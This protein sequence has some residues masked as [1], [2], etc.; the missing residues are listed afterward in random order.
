MTPPVPDV[1]RSLCPGCGCTDG[2]FPCPR[3]GTLAP[4]RHEPQPAETTAPA[5][6]FLGV[7]LFLASGVF[8]VMVPPPWGPIG[9]VMMGGIGT[10]MSGLAAWALRD[11]PRPWQVVAPDA[12]GIGV[13][14]K[15]VLQYTHGRRTRRTSVDPQ[16][17]AALSALDRAGLQA[18]LE[19]MLDAPEMAAS[20]LAPLLL[21]A[22][23]ARGVTQAEQT[24]MTRW[25][26][27]QDQPPEVAFDDLH[28][29]PEEPPSLT[30]DDDP[31]EALGRW[32]DTHPQLWAALTTPR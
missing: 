10:A 32:K 23:V 14:Q 7:S 4:T 17:H 24:T 13:V 11:P 3:C 25:A 16:M 2:A 20:A 28:H 27:G 9:G 1:V 21:L 22:R 5:V 15:G 30:G 8:L 18:G 6:L 31:A 29:P 12:V 19:A 26:D